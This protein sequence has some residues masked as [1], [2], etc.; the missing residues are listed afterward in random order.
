[1][2]YRDDSGSLRIGGSFSQRARE[3]DAD[4][5]DDNDADA[6]TMFVELGALDVV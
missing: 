6:D 2:L 1:M 3:P 5:H 4:A